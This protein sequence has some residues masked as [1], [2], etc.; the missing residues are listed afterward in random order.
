MTAADETDVVE[1]AIQWRKKLPNSNLTNPPLLLWRGDENNDA[2]V[3]LA[4]GLYEDEFSSIE[5]ELIEVQ[6]KTH[7]GRTIKE[8]CRVELDHPKDE[9]L[10]RK[11]NG[12]AGSGS[13]FLFQLQIR[14]ID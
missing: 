2:T 10:A 1:K 4:L 8:V 14:F 3:A 11:L 7:D 12:L 6:V 13:D 5:H 9:K